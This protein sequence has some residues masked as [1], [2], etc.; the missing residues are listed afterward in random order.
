MLFV[1]QNV[2]FN[3]NETEWKIENSI[4]TFGERNFVKKRERF[5]TFLFYLSVWYIE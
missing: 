5:L 1:E 2:E 4:H 3:K